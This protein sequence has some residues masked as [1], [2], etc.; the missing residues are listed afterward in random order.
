MS[1]KNIN[2]IS[3]MR[4]N[5]VGPEMRSIKSL[6]TRYS[7]DFLSMPPPKS[8]RCHSKQTSHITFLLQNSL[9][10]AVVAP[11][12]TTNISQIGETKIQKQEY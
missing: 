6:P 1:H 12:F 4:Q 5:L 8:N 2:N 11:I 10:A 7:N 3:K 9:Y